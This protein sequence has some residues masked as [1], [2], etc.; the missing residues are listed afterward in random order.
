MENQVTNIEQSRR[1]LELGIPAEKA[2]MRWGI[3]R[4][5]GEDNSRCKLLLNNQDVFADYA[6]YTPAFTVADLL[7]MLP[8]EIEYEGVE[9]YVSFIYEEISKSLYVCYES[10]EYGGHRPYVYYQS[11][12]M[13]SSIVSCIEWL[14][15]N[16]M[17]LK[18]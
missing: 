10:H 13:V 8:F 7:A 3:Y 17:N 6:T 18:L 4:D 12:P 2:S 9:M 16:G 11:N 1:L 14:D 15:E 5:F